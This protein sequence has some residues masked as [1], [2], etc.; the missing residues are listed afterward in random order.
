MS[1]RVC[2]GPI[3]EYNLPQPLASPATDHLILHYLKVLNVV[4]SKTVLPREVEETA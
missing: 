1:I 2:D 4:R 3:G